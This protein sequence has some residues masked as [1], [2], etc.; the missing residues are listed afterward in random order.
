MNFSPPPPP[1]PQRN[2]AI[3]RC[4]NKPG[5]RESE[6]S[7]LKSCRGFWLLRQFLIAIRSRI[8]PA[9]IPRRRINYFSPPNTPSPPK[10]IK[11]YH[12]I[13]DRMMTPLDDINRRTKK[14]ERR[15]RYLLR[16][17][18]KDREADPIP[19]REDYRYAD[20][21]LACS[22]YRVIGQI[23]YRSLCVYRFIGAR[24]PAFESYQ[25]RV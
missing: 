13:A 1:P 16:A 12:I 24:N 23:G 9:F 6:K 22:K 4:R 19:Y 11:K 2:K 15:S 8:S 3:E 25:G 17:E 7:E 10:D 18:H 5:E 14:R 20:V 21:F